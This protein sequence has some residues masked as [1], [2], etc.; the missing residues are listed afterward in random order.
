M[1]DELLD[2]AHVLD[3]LVLVPDL[4]GAGFSLEATALLQHIGLQLGDEEEL[5]QHLVR[6]ERWVRQHDA[7][8][9]VGPQ[10]DVFEYRSR[11]LRRDLERRALA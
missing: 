3:G 4:L 9:R 6:R 5:P 2:L 1:V 11:W 7:Q 10:L 8:E